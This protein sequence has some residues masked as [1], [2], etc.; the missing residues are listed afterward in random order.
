MTIREIAHLADSALTYCDNFDNVAYRSLFLCISRINAAFDFGDLEAISFDPLVIKGAL[1]LPYFL[2]PNPL[3]VSLTVRRGEFVSPGGLPSEYFLFQNY[4][5][6]FNP[7]TTISFDLPE[8]AVVTL[9]VYNTLGQEVSVLINHEVM[10]EG[11]EDVEFDA[12]GLPSGV[13]FYRIAAQAVV[14][15]KQGATGRTFL[16]VK[17]MLLVK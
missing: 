12:T 13:Y 4:P 9:K 5:N 8:Q 3:A 7:T 10:E 14:D 2:A 15:Q 16:D 17:K 1:P 6:P 11:T